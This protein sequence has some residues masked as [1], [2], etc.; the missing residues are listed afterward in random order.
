MDPPTGV[1]IKTLS[2]ISVY[3]QLA[4]RRWLYQNLELSLIIGTLRFGH[5]S[6]VPDVF[7]KFIAF[8][9]VSASYAI[10]IVSGLYGLLSMREGRLKGILHLA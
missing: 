2:Q 9:V 5:G 6:I 3:S 4:Y 10:A 8:R 7:K 1:K